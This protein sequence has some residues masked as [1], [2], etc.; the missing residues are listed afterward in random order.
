MCK[1]KKYKE[2]AEKQ[3]IVHGPHFYRFSASQLS[4]RAADLPEAGAVATYEHWASYFGLEMDNT[5]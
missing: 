3:E 1:S 5:F 4:G 2:A